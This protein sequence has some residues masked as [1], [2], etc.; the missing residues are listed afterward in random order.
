MKII[1]QTP[2]FVIR[3]FKP[4]EKDVYLSLFSDEQVMLYI[5]KRSRKEN[6]AVFHAALSDY[7]SGRVLGRWGMFNNTDNDFIGLC[8]LRNYDDSAKQIELGYVLKQKFWGKGIAGE[9][10]Q[11]M[12]GYGFTHTDKHSIVAVT[13]LEN[14]ASQKVLEKV[15]FKRMDNFLRDDQELAFYK[16]DKLL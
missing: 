12:V 14:I 4:E 5:P 3:D 10:A 11:I 7:D 13:A 9:M 1:A 2:R 16:I 6:I 8:L 15:G